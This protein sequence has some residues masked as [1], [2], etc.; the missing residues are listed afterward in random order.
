MSGIIGYH[1]IK[2]PNNN[3]RHLERKKEYKK[4]PENNYHN[5]NHKLLSINNYL[6]C[7]WVK[8]TNQKNEVARWP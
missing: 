6:E 2:L 4:W 5:G 3:G 7:K 8:F 1:Y